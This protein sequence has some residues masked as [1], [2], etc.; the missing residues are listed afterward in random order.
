M[1]FLTLIVDKNNLPPITGLIPPY[2]PILALH[3]RISNNVIYSPRARPDGSAI[4][5]HHHLRYQFTS[6]ISINQS[7]RH[8][9]RR[10]TQFSLIQ[11]H[12]VTH[13][14]P[15][16]S[17]QN[18]PARNPCDP[19]HPT[20]IPCFN[21][22]CSLTRSSNHIPT[23]RAGGQVPC[24]RFSFIRRSASSTSQV[25]RQCA[26]CFLV[27]RLDPTNEAAATLAL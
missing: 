10:L 19:F 7:R 27:S 22:T 2:N 17:A 16:H 4:V 8:F 18:Y 23:S 21:S 9:N 3:G 14:A 12:H 24:G 26:W 15:Q 6:I 13:N 20:Y 11:P 1:R 25:F 5:L